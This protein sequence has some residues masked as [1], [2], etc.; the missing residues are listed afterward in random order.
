MKGMLEVTRHYDKI[1]QRTWIQHKCSKCGSHNITP[2][3]KRQAGAT[4]VCYYL[5]EECGYSPP[6]LVIYALEGRWQ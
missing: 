1:S 4:S 3:G 2:M 6:D 5:C